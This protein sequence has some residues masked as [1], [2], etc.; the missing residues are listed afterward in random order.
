VIATAS[1]ALSPVAIENALGGLETSLAVL[2]DLAIVEAWCLIGE[3]RTPARLALCGVLAGLCLLARIDSAFLV[4]MLGAFELWTAVSSPSNQRPRRLGQL[5]RIVGVAVLVVA[6]WWGYCTLRF[7]GPI[8][9]SGKAVMEVVAMHAENY[10][11]AQAMGWAAGTI[12]GT[13]FVDARD[14]RVLLFMRPVTGAA[15]WIGVVAAFAMLARRTNWAGREPILALLAHG[16]AIFAFYALMLPALWFFR[17]YLAPTEAAAALVIAV[18]IARTWE[19]GGRWA[20]PALAVAGI[21]LVFATRASTHLLT[22]DPPTTM[23][24]DYHGAKGYREAVRDV[25]VKCPHGAILGSFQSGALSY[26]G[27]GKVQVVNLDGVVDRRAHEAVRQK[28]L[29]DYAYE[30]GVTHLADWRLNLENF[31]H[32]SVNAHMMRER[33]TP[34]VAARPQGAD[35]FILEPLHWPREARK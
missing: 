35:R 13:P 18:A 22:H 1:W 12:L 33:S 26:Y 32:L 4:L 25:L 7:G 30:R 9:E 11:T 17:R 31:D 24:R 10:D 2:L 19:R 27:Y 3:R 6:P 28:R 23:D 5:A 8:P 29:S 16:V 15:L 20:W 34:I 14:L 21:G